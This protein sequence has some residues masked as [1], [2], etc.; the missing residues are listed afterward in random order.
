MNRSIVTS[1]VSLV[2]VMAVSSTS[3]AEGMSVHLNGGATE[4]ASLANA[5][6]MFSGN[7]FQLGQAASGDVLFN[8][9]PHL[10]LGPTASAFYYQDAQPDNKPATLWHFGLA[11]RLQ[12]DHTNDLVPYV[13]VSGGVSD[14]DHVANPSMD[15][16]LGLDLALEQSH[17]FFAGPYVSWTH[18]WDT[19]NGAQAS[20]T[21]GNAFN[22]VTVGLSFSFDLPIHPKVVNHVVVVKT[23]SAPV[24]TPVVCSPVVE[25]PAPAPERHP[26]FMVMFDKNSSAL[27]DHQTVTLDS[28]VA[29]MKSNP[30]K[31]AVVQGRSSSEGPKAYN[32]TLSKARADVVVA[33]LVAHGVDAHRMVASGAG[34]VGNPGNHM[35]RN[36][37]VI[38]LR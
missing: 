7:K 2:A 8:L 21:N 23:P 10:S 3:Y 16:A 24:A 18:T 22:A 27:T 26:L 15:A 29:Y 32:L 1:L 5:N 33:Y 30:N 4:Q 38:V 34:G 13:Q 36:T 12:G 28:L 25:T 35:N 37:I 14:Q 20:L 17:T 31:V 6:Q 9:T 11:L 19:N